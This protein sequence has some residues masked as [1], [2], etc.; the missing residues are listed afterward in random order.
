MNKIGDILNNLT[1]KQERSERAS[2]LKEII[3]IINEERQ[4]TKFK[5]VTGSQ[6]GVKTSH[7]SKDDLYYVLSEG[8]DYKKRNGSFSKYFFGVLKVK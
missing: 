2:I 3:T 6:I 5:P 4:G 7:L 1:P 8:K